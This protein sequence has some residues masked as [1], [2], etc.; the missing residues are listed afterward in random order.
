MPFQSDIYESVSIK[1]NKSGV[2][3]NLPLL[4][5]GTG[6]LFAMSKDIDFGTPQEKYIDY[7]AFDIQA[8]S[9]VPALAIE[10]GWRDR[11]SDNVDWLPKQYLA[12]N[13]PVVPI[14]AQGVLF[15]LKITDEFPV[16]QWKLSRVEA[17]GKL[18]GLGRIG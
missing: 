3:F 11:M 9:D 14:R 13:N 18:V 2:I 4:I 12:F 8:P 7:L 15:T 6:E 5:A 17:Y 10:V 16:V 1:A